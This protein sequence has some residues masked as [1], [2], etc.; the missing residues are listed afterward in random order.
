MESSLSGSA[1]MRVKTTAGGNRFSPA[2][3]ESCRE[4]C[5]LPAGKYDL[6]GLSNPLFDG[7]L[8]A[9][10]TKN[11]PAQEPRPDRGIEWNTRNLD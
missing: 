5:L 3:V 2:S 8:A 1:K 10:A 11:R 7:K 6:Y 4:T 9:A